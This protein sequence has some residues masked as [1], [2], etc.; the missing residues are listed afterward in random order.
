MAKPK[1]NPKHLA[2]LQEGL[3]YRTKELLSANFKEVILDRAWKKHL[4]L[5]RDKNKK[6]EA[7]SIEDMI[8]KE[9]SVSGKPKFPTLVL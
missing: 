6:L 3:R 7:M 9:G 1:P 8:E 5:Q 4:E 2:I